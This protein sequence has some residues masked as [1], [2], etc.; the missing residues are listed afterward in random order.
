MAR[1]VV[2]ADAGAETPIAGALTAVFLSLGILFLTPWLAYIPTPVL[3]ASIIVAVYQLLEFPSMMKLLKTNRI[4]GIITWATAILVLTWEVE[5]GL[6]IGVVLSLIT[7][8]ASHRKPYMAVL[9]RIPGTERFKNV[10]HADTETLPNTL[11]V[12]IDESLTFMNAGVVE[13]SLLDYVASR[14]ELN[15]LVL[16]AS[17]IHTIDATGANMLKRFRQEVDGAGITFYMTDIKVP[18]ARKLESFGLFDESAQCSKL[19]TIDVYHK[20][21]PHQ[22]G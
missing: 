12:R 3:A 18:L 14:Q 21:S 16:V 4:D 22:A 20:L 1:S 11:F 15:K 9:G 13:Q 7:L 6:L 10:N 8:L 17:G 19:S 5:A 2:N